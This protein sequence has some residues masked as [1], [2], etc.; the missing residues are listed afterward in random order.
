MANT[1]SLCLSFV[2]LV[3]SAPAASAQTA[4]GT[5]PDGGVA[6]EKLHRSN[7][8]PE[9]GGLFGPKSWAPPVREKKVAPPPPPPPEPPPL[10]YA[11]LGKWTENDETLIVLSKQRENVLVRGGET[12]DD[13][14]RVESVGESE[15]V[16]R[17]LPL[18]V[19][20]VLSFSKPQRAAAPPRP[21]L[22]HYPDD[23]DDEYEEDG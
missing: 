19:T 4:D 1:A 5:N 23:E 22:P 8:A 9:P 20:Q 18:D 14:Y 15:L 2:A 3:M 10:P 13:I 11:Y 21:R 6:L 12:L 7:D 17:Y 16:L